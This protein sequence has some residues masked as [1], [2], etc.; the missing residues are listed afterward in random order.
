MKDVPEGRLE[1]LMLPAPSLDGSMS[2]F[3][4]LESRCTTRDIAGERLS[5]QTLSDLLWAAQGINRQAGPFGGTGRTAGSASNSQEIR[6]YV[7]LEEGTYLYEPEPHRLVGVA[8]G[9]IRHLAISRGQQPAG[10][11]APLRLVYVADVERFYHAGFPEPGLYDPEVQ[12]SYYYVDTGLIAENVFL[13]AASLGLGAWFHNCDKQ[14]F[15]EA[16][17]LEAAMR[18]L[19]GQTVGLLDSPRNPGR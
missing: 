5:L 16:V 12:K 19:F 17:G 13:A 8:P 2:V 18:P 1:P 9:D 15:V 6:V 14:G 11:D 3:E 4:A 7:L 10:A